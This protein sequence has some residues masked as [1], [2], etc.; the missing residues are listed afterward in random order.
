MYFRVDFQPFDLVVVI[1]KTAMDLS[2]TDYSAD[3]M[4]LNDMTTGK[5]LPV[6][7]A[8]IAVGHCD[9]LPVSGTD[10]SGDDEGFG[11]PSLDDAFKQ[12]EQSQSRVTEMAPGS[13]KATSPLNEGVGIVVRIWYRHL[14]IAPRFTLVSVSSDQAHCELLFVRADHELVTPIL[15]VQF[16]RGRSRHRSGWCLVVRSDR[17]CFNTALPSQQVSVLLWTDCRSVN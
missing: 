14:L 10:R 4:T 9:V 6:C 5:I 1:G 13:E 7:D 12:L 15:F 17:R 3:I 11:S 2:E 16:V 8:L